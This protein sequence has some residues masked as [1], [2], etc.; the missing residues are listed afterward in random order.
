MKGS[1]SKDLELLA[2]GLRETKQCCSNKP[3]FENTYSLGMKWFVC[4]EC[5]EIEWFK[6]DIKEKVRIR[7]EIV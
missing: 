7:N 3:I 4:N 2:I 6:T 5:L 1:Q